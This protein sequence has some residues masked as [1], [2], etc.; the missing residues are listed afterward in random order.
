MNIF[1]SLDDYHLLEYLSVLSN[2]NKYELFKLINKSNQN[3][4]IFILTTSLQN[5]YN[6][7]AIHIKNYKPFKFV[8]KCITLSFIDLC[9]AV[10]ANWSNFSLNFC[11]QF[12]KNFGIKSLFLFLNSVQLQNELKKATADSSKYMNSLLS[13]IYSKLLTTVFNLVIKGK[14]EFKNELIE[15][16]SLETLIRLSLNFSDCSN[17]QMKAYMI[18]ANLL[19][20]ETMKNID[21]LVHIKTIVKELVK[22]ASEC[23]QKISDGTNLERCLMIFN[24]KNEELNTNNQINEVTIIE[25]SESFFYLVDILNVLYNFALNDDIKYDIYV[26]YSLENYLKL[27]IFNGNEIEKEYSLMLLW[28]L[29]FDQRVADL[30]KKDQK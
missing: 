21:Q 11:K 26:T 28:Q 24:N 12:V 8:L 29:C 16:N 15:A 25:I 10:V 18:I 30:L 22:Y 23:A 1:N 3:N 2:R 6:D 5:L 19:N 13:N 20:E 14:T 9:L 7:F 4:L 17:I 27:I